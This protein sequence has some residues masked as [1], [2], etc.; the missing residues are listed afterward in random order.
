MNIESDITY[1]FCMGVF[2]NKNKRICKRNRFK[3]N[4]SEQIELQSTD[5][6][7]CGKK[8]SR[9]KQVRDFGDQIYM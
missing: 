5:E 1:L 8:N 3:Q 7:K 6:V 2:R 4:Y 9:Q